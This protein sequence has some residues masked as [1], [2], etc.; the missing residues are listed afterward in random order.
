MNEGVFIGALIAVGL[1]MVIEHVLMLSWHYGYFTTGI[2]TYQKRTFLSHNVNLAPAIN[3]VQLAITPTYLHGSIEF[4]EIKP[5]VFLFRNKQ[6]ELRLYGLNRGD[7]TRRVLYYHPATGEIEVKGY[8]NWSLLPIWGFALMASFLFLISNFSV[9]VLDVEIL[10]VVAIF[11]F[12]LYPAAIDSKT[13]DEVIYQL[14]VYYR[15]QL[16]S[17]R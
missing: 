5:N 16:T 10:I 2:L 3:H 17:M 15:K 12:S 14:K 8:L 11:I 6:Y 9:L 4:N 1:C 13:N 7:G